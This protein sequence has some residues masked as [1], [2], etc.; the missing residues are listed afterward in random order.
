M[1]DQLTDDERQR[2]LELFIQSDR[3]RDDKITIDELVLDWK[4]MGREVTEEDVRPYFDKLDTNGDGAIDFDEFLNHLAEKFK[5]G[6]TEQDIKNLWGLFDQDGDGFVDKEELGRV[7]NGLGMDLPDG[8][9]GAILNDVDEDKDGKLNY[10][11]KFSTVT[12][13]ELTRG[14][15][16]KDTK[17]AR[18]D[19][20]INYKEGIVEFLKA[21]GADTDEEN[22]FLEQISSR[23]L[24]QLDGSGKLDFFN[25]ERKSTSPGTFSSA[26]KTN[27]LYIA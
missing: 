20:Q 8:A 9:I 6:E 24:T 14:I 5:E 27:T 23:K 7:L 18:T 21:I 15:A 26:Y 22:A 11:G 19:L 16:P 12:V 17:E 1:A 3:N 10:E 2:I 4:A 13:R 25:G